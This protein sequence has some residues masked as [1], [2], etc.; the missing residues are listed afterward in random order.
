[1]GQTSTHH[2]LRGGGCKFLFGIIAAFV[3]LPLLAQAQPVS[4]TITT[5]NV[6]CFGLCNGSAT[7]TASGGWAPYVYLWSNG[8]TSPTI[9]GLCPGNYTVTVTDIDLGFTIVSTTITQ[10]TQLGATVNVQQNQ[11]CSVAPD[12]QASVTP[13]GGTPPYSYLW[14]TGATTPL[15]NGLLAGNYSVTVTDANGCTV[16]ASATLVLQPEGL[17][18]VDVTTDVTCFGFNNGTIHIGVMTGT[19]PYTFQ[20]SNGVTGSNPDLTNLGPGT[21]SVTVTDANGC[22]AQHTATV[23]QPPQLVI[24]MSMTNALCGLPGSATVA[25]SG[26]TPPYSVQW[27]TGSSNF[28]IQGSAGNYSVTVTD[29]NACTAT[30]T[31]TIGGTN[32]GLTVTVAPGNNAGCLAGGTATATASGGTG[33]YAYAWDNGQTT[34]T[35]TNLSAGPHQVTVTDITTGCSG[36]GTVTISSSGTPTVTILVTTNATCLVG[37]TATVSATGGTSPY[38]FALNNGVIVGNLA[39]NLTAGSYIVTVTDATGCTA[40]ATA[41]V[42]QSQGPNVTVV[43]NTSA[44]CTAGGSA[45]ATATGG[46]GPYV[47]L[48]DNG[49]TTATATN[50]SPGVHTVTVTD[51]AGCSATGTVTITQ[52]G[53]PTVIISASSG[54]SCTTGGSVTVGVTG[55]T[56]PYTFLFSNGATTATVNNLSAGSYTVT[57]TDAAGCTATATLSIAA[58]LLPNVV[59]TASS[60]AKCDQPGSATATASGGTPPFTYRWDNGET[61]MTAVNLTAGVH[62]V[63][64]TD[65][66]GCTA[67]ASVN[68]GFAANGIR[69]GDFIFYD[70]DQNG[71]QSPLETGVPNVTV[72]LIRAGTDGI[73]GNADDVVVQ[74]TTTNSNGK[75]EF[76]CVTPGTYIIM[77][78]SIPSGFQFTARN[79]VNNDCLDSDAN[80]LGKT[81]AF[82]VVAGQAD[83]L[84]VDAGIST[85][86]I[87][88]VNAG[89]ICCDQMICEGMVPAALFGVLPPTG[90]SGAIQY[91][92]MQ[93]LALG[94][95]PAEW[96]FIAGATG[97]TYQPGALFE[98]SFFQRCARRAGCVDYLESNIITITVKQAG[99]G[100]CPGFI[101]S[102][103]ALQQGPASVLVSWETLPE[104]DDYMYTVE[105]SE[106]QVV[107]NKLATVMG[108][109]NTTQNNSYSTMDQTPVSGMNFYRI[110]RSNDNGVE[111]FSKAVSL[112]L[113][114]EGEQALVIAPNPVNDK[115]YIKNVA[116]YA[117]DVTIKMFTTQGKLLQTK[118]I[119]QGTMMQDNIEMG[120]MP[121][122]IYIV[123]VDFGDG[124]TKTLKITK[125]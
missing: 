84:C 46:T 28:T 83:N 81:D 16:V 10:P 49:Q 40:T 104:N 66:A 71:F 35:A 15:I 106:N 43:A 108:K 1:M 102:I 94:P 45:T 27:S 64:V 32:T 118:V 87:P 29:A 112:E 107:W 24:G 6:T 110:K 120:D 38:T 70:V 76:A 57:V 117:S 92:W 63:T 25:P 119:K 54:A 69:V 26:G 99:T 17:W 91:Q 73:F 100:G 90:G 77:F 93:F 22:T 48:F 9:N 39:S 4:A 86:C 98:T 14:S 60:N 30:K 80:A 96:V 23:T 52:V 8:S 68:I 41:T 123:R 19:P 44:T 34:Q 113:K 3:L 109:H 75:Y 103:S 122:G 61:T 78:S 11:L 72:M 13:F 59:I 79:A 62:T 65:A 95:A 20:F 97:E 105:H 36:V 111:A 18:L 101:S 50:L 42:T 89:T 115:L 53:T 7:V 125:F 74:T 82:T 114:L 51:A 33:N 37:G 5:T 31:L 56:A 85:I 58:A 12:G 21:Y 88:L 124:T 116:Q 2:I 121:Q 67:T 55:G 47:F